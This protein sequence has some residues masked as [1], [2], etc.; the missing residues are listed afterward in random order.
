MWKYCEWSTSPP[1]QQK[2]SI[3]DFGSTRDEEVITLFKETKSKKGSVFTFHWPVIELRTLY[4][5][6]TKKAAENLLRMNF[7]QIYGRGI[8]FY[9]VMWWFDKILSTV[10]FILPELSHFSHSLSGTALS[11]T[12]YSTA[13]PFSSWSLP[14]IVI[15]TRT[16]WFHVHIVHI[17]F[18]S[19]TT[20]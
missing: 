1:T 13:N 10:N 5:L 7:V 9:W 6:P 20:F 2:I 11:F 14:I 16:Y 3:I 8:Q 17:D 18:M 15:H 4:R 19:W 12:I